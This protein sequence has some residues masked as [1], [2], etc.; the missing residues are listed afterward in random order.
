[1]KLNLYY[2]LVPFTNS[3][4]L[5]KYEKEATSYI[6]QIIELIDVYNKPFVNIV[7]PQ[8][9]DAEYFNSSKK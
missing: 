5:L 4:K 1:M 2:A 9:N 3:R 6:K 8:T 7:H